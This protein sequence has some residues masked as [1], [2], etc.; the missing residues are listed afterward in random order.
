MGDPGLPGGSQLV[1]SQPQDTGSEDD[2]QPQ[3]WGYEVIGALV[4]IAA[5]AVVAGYLVYRRR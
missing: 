1:D 2:S 5:I 4:L 3:G